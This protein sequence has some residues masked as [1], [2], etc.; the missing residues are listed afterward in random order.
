VRLIGLFFIATG[1]LPAQFSGL[2]VTGDGRLFFSTPLITAQEDNREKIY[3]IDGAGLH[4]HATAGTNG[5]AVAISP[6]TSGDGTITG[7]GLNYPCRTGSC[8][9]AGGPRTFFTLTGAN[10]TDAPFNSLQ[11]SRNGRFLLGSTHDV[12]TQL[13]EVPSGRIRHLPQFLYT[14]GRQTI[15]NTGAFLLRNGQ[16]S[17]SPLLYVAHGEEARAIPGTDRTTA[18]ILSPDGSRI[19]FHNQ[20][21]G[22]VELILAGSDGSNPRVL[23]FRAHDPNLSVPDAVFVPS[24]A[25]DNSLLYRDADNQPFVLTHG[26]EPKLIQQIP[27]GV[28]DLIL[29]GNGRIA[30]LVTANGQILRANLDTSSPADEFVPETPTGQPINY[31][32]SPGSVVR[33][34]GSGFSAR[35]HLAVGGVALPI[36]EHTANGIA[37]QIPWEFNPSTASSRLVLQGPESPFRQEVGLSPITYPTVSFERVPGSGALQAA[38]Q[39]FRGIVTPADPARRGETIHIF[40]RNLGPVDQPVA[41]GQPSPTD[42]VARIVTPFACY[43]FEVDAPTGR[44]VRARGLVVPFAGLSGGLIG[45]YHI[46][47]TIPDDWPSQL[48]EIQCLMAAPEGTFRGDIA[49]IYVAP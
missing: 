25:N 18:A 16:A 5:N 33:L 2:A 37:A 1:L 31:L 7:Y 3:R 43:A 22:G 14:P 34:I 30:W 4:L 19:A 11:I 39:D 23:A 15:A 28:Q 40:A 44:P 38:H 9:L 42:P 10:L 8:G 24:F 26:S 13:I 6:L 35:T 36:S 17:P 12:R 41:T 46:D 47:V 48:A 32:A 29:S 27:G 21:E 20:T 49:R 45:I